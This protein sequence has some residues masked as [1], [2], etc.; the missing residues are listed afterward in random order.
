MHI[1]IYIVHIYRSTSKCS[2]SKIR[3]HLILLS[4][5]QVMLRRLF[6]IFPRGDLKWL[7][8]L[9]EILLP[10]KNYSKE[11]LSNLLRCSEE[12]PSFIDTQGKGWMKW[13]LLR[14]NRTCM[15]IQNIF[16]LQFALVS[17][18]FLLQSEFNF[19]YFVLCS[20]DHIV[21]VY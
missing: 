2:I 10:F 7:Q 21:I 16:I 17:F 3:T 8:R 5:S 4:G 18:Q 9:L 6:V 14:L 15:V 20:T 19:M 12:K 13:N 1:Y 11:F